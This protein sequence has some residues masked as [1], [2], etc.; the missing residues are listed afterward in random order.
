MYQCHKKQIRKRFCI[1]FVGLFALMTS[2]LSIYAAVGAPPSFIEKSDGGHT[3]SNGA[4][5][6]FIYQ[7][8][9][10][11]YDR[12]SETALYE[13]GQYFTVENNSAK[14][15][16]DRVYLTN[17]LFNRKFIG[18]YSA[19]NGW[20]AP[21]VYQR[22]VWF[23]A[24]LVSGAN[25]LIMEG[26]G[27]D[28]GTG[29][30]LLR[31]V[32]PRFGH[33]P[34]VHGVN[35]V[36]TQGDITRGIRTWQ[37]LYTDGAT[38]SS[39]GNK[40]A[41][42]TGFFFSDADEQVQPIPAYQNV[43]LSQNATISEV[44]KQQTN[45]SWKTVHWSEMDH[46]GVYRIQCCTKDQAGNSACAYRNVT[47][48]RRQFTVTFQDWDHTVLK[49]QIVDQGACATPPTDP[50][51]IGYRF[52][53]WD[54]DYCQVTQDMIIQAQYEPN[55]YIIR[56][57]GNQADSGV[58]ADSSHRYDVTQPLDKNS[59]ERNGYRFIG[60]N[61]NQNSSDVEFHDEQ[62][63]KNLTSKHQDVVT[64]YAIW[65]KAPQITAV[66]RWF[67][68][69]ED[70]DEERLMERVQAW[71][72][73]DGDITHQAYIAEH[74]ILEHTIGDYTITYQV[75]D[76]RDQIATITVNVHI[77]NHIP[78]HEEQIAYL[79]FIDSSYLHTL[80]NTSIWRTVPYD[81]L[82]RQTLD[83]PST[84]ETWILDEN[85]IK[86]IRAFNETHDF[87]KES[88][89]AFYEQFAHLRQ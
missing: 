41:T 32:V 54:Q 19:Y 56:Y 40:K 45:G 37:S 57:H 44:A 33:D 68:D 72:Q 63:V 31:I 7:A 18:E 30:A 24:T 47:V 55:T 17:R 6:E 73:E 58:M 34:Q 36:W 82:L 50:Q 84:K 26:Q 81:T 1:F 83:T 77:V 22:G 8:A 60:W 89:A 12:R 88:D 75:H 59:Y 71:D 9:L 14:I 38:G 70:I 49:Q 80:K 43:P 11:Q 76:S 10:K 52:Q 42:S 25:V 21:G 66:D 74:N 67:Y 69:D 87:S 16:S 5:T 35:G 15:L 29:D 2:A 61:R 62:A 39:E 46:P 79:R 65:D 53:G 85:A 51:R 78:H 28:A 3:T 86:Q 13:I 4:H 64:L 48:K 23:E 20:Q 27:G